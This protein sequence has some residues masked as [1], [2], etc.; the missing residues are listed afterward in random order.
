MRT[1]AVRTAQWSLDDDGAT[2]RIRDLVPGDH[3]QLERL[4]ESLPPRDQYLRFFTPGRVNAERYADSVLDGA[5]TAHPVLG[6]FRGDLLIGTAGYAAS[7]R[8]ATAELA[9]A[10]AHDA[11]AHGVGTL[12]I[13]ALVSRA[14]SAG[15]AVLTADVLAENGRMLRVLTDLGLP[16]RCERD[17]EVVHVTIALDPGERYRAAVDARERSADLASLTPVLRPRSVAVIGAGRTAGSVGHAVLRNIIRAG[18]TGTL[19]AVNPHALSILGVPCVSSVEMLAEAPDLA[20]VCVPA[21]VV[22]PVLAE[23]AA[24]GVRAVLVIT[25]GVTGELAA[26]AR[27]LVRAHGMRMVGPNCLGIANT[28]PDIRLDATF[29]AEPVPAG[30]IGVLTQSGGVAIALAAGLGLAGTGVSTLVSAGDKVDV[31]GN[32]LLHW[33]TADPATTA[34]L[35]HLESFGN[36]RR[37]ARLAQTLSA[38]KPVV[39][40]RAGVS[41][42]G[43]RAAGSH[44]A[45]LATPAVTLDALYRHAGLTAVDSVNEAVEALALLTT[46]PLPAGPRTAIVTNAGGA[47]VL[48][49]DAC[50]RY[51]LTVP[52][53]AEQTLRALRGGL[54][55]NAAVANPVD[56]TATVGADVLAHAVAHVLRDD[57]VDAVIALCVPTALGDPAP[58]ALRMAEVAHRSGKPLLLVRLGG[59]AACG[60]E[61]EPAVPV[62]AEPHAAV[63]ALAHAARRR[64]WLDQPRP[65]A[66]PVVDLDREAVDRVLAAHPDG[67]WLDPRQ[68]LALLAAAGVPVEAGRVVPVGG[69]VEAAV[70]DLITAGRP[71]ALKAVTDGLLHKREAGGVALGLTDRGGIET[72]VDALRAGF[73][74]RLR[75]VFVQPMAGPGTEVLI[76]V[77]G[78]ERFGPL[79]VC[80]TGG[81]RA[82]SGEHG[83][84]LCPLSEVDI[85]EL[86][87]GDPLVDAVL[88]RVAHLAEA[89]PEIAELDLNPLIVTDTHAVA[90]DARVRLAPVSRVDPLRRA[91]RG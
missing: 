28:A 63:R 14:R 39:V 23:C 66:H 41:A 62:Y 64:A 3:D 33:W 11:Q 30:G 19:S 36:P 57:S 53:L 61:G 91:L 71:V 45:A 60:H 6:A 77:R 42:A 21:T 78:D 20:V 59:Q 70:A 55:L 85:V 47:G 4:H 90:V 56:T 46:Q 79:V 76:G 50:A 58:G 18:F 17:D 32:D 84:R 83:A 12:L 69:A 31:S 51:G 80:G 72:A 10:V 34:V 2:V 87:G 13:E 22:L 44:T 7:E 82:E 24:R 15:I 54:P 35:V 75:G 40:V 67:G 65:R 49:A 9:V 38:A 48:A 68:S 43:S 26:R 16:V 89:V 86:S 74:D 88:R 52:D 1:D 73:G 8:P 37:F 25:S 27:D 29:A 5:N 81:T